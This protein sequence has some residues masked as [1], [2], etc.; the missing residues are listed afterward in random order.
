[1]Q[2]RK[3]DYARPLSLCLR[4]NP[5]NLVPTFTP[6]PINLVHCSRRAKLWILETVSRIIPPATSSPPRA[7]SRKLLEPG[8]IAKSKGREPKNRK[9][10]RPILSTTSLSSEETYFESTRNWC[11][12][13]YEASVKERSKGWIV[14]IAWKVLS[15]NVNFQFLFVDRSLE[16]QL[17]KGWSQRRSRRIIT[18]FQVIRADLENRNSNSSEGWILSSMTQSRA[19]T[20]A[21]KSNQSFPLREISFPTP[22]RF[23]ESSPDGQSA[24]I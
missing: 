20:I 24:A 16:I 14:C 17:F 13:V 21:C 9:E 1:M 7:Q 22:S 3:T 18:H 12:I 19:K 11:A 4:Q 23:E 15:F 10:M 8:N 5:R 2:Q 6:F